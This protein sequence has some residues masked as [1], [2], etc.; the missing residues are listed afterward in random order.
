MKRIAILITALAT[1]IVAA[2]LVFILM[3]GV[4]IEDNSWKYSHT[5]TAA[6]NTA[7]SVGIT[8]ENGILTLTGPQ[9]EIDIAYKYTEIEIGKNTSIYALESPEYTGHAIVMT[10][11]EYKGDMVGQMAVVRTDDGSFNGSFS[12]PNRDGKLLI[13]VING[14]TVYF[15]D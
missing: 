14:Y 13:V 2:A 10:T 15:T 7:N 11:K 9:P 6:G 3:P 1:A 5:E 4:K 8:T 12:I